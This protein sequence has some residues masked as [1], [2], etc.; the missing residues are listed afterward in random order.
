MPVLVSKGLKEHKMGSTK[1]KLTEKDYDELLDK[2][3]MEVDN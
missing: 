2:A 1:D 3:F